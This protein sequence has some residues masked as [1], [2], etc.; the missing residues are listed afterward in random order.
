MSAF[1]VVIVGTGTNVGKTHVGQAL[2]A[3][4]A[5]RLA[6]WKPI[7]S[8]ATAESSDTRALSRAGPT[9]PP[10]YSLSEPISPH[11]AARRQGVVI[12]RS[13]VVEGA[14][15]QAVESEVLLIET[16]GG[17]FSPLD[18]KLTNADLV[19]ALAPSRVLLVAADRLG[20][21]HDVGATVGAARA[22]GLGIDALVLSTPEHPD[23]STGT[24]RAELEST[25][26][27]RVAAV[28]PRAAFDAAPSRDAARE[29]LD[30]MKC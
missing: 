18:V 20:V 19:L 7:E 6:A 27:I 5:G 17:L 24:N 3:S 14:R 13:L 9:H 4:G 15:R 12:D 28:F 2:L 30:A 10:L 1:I 26:G 22:L 11:L 16:A 29:T 21:L 8:G 25:V 23:P